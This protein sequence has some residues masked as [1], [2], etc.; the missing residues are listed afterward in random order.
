[1]EIAED[2]CAEEPMADQPSVKLFR[3]PQIAKCRQ[4]Q[5]GVVG[6]K[7]IIIP[8]IPRNWNSSEFDFLLWIFSHILLLSR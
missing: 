2:I 7:G 1:M 4:Q 8:E 6:N 5:K 3:A